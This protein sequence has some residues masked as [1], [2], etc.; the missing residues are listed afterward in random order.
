MGK[1]VESESYQYVSL[2]LHIVNVSGMRSRSVEVKTS[3][4]T[5]VDREVGRALL[6]NKVS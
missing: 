2:V 6:V 3:L 4:L 1:G 5:T